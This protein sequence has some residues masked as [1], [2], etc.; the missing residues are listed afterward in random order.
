MGHLD[1][2]PVLVK[3]SVSLRSQFSAKRS[4]AVA[5]PT[6]R[7][8][9]LLLKAALNDD[10]PGLA[11]QCAYSLV[12]SFFAF[13]LL[14]LFVASYSSLTFS[15]GIPRSFLSTLPSDIRQ[16]V[17]TQVQK[18]AEH[19][20]S[21]ALALAALLTLYT[22]SAGMARLVTAVNRAYRIVEHRPWWKR[23]AVG[24]L[25][26]L[27]GL[28]L[29]FLPAIWGLL[30]SLITDLLA[31]IGLEERLRFLSWL[32]W[33]IM[34]VGAF[35]WLDL[36]FAVAPE[37]QHRWRPLT[38]GAFVAAIGLLLANFGIFSYVSRLE[39]MSVTYGTVGGFMVLLLWLYVASFIL[40]MGAEVNAV[41]EAPLK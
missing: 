12:F 39:T 28:V 9:K 32:R 4:V 17:F 27:A 31:G 25:L 33:P 24:A 19:P 14:L 10:V 22:T 7:F 16:M 2:L 8:L 38:P 29:V 40:I 23:M 36:L 26:T 20:R 41:L 1:V 11:S 15:A 30:G 13:I 5:M 6:A 37:C 35:G 3:A 34:V 18:L 21:G